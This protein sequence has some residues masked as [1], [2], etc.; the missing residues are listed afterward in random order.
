MQKALLEAMKETKES[1]EFDAVK[2]AEKQNHNSQNEHRSRGMPQNTHKYC[3][4]ICRQNKCPA[5][6]K[7]CVRKS[8]AS[9]FE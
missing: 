9:H 6:G 5:Y 7:N 2:K 4:T 3:S 8:R 1:K